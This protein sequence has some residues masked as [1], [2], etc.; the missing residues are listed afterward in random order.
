MGWR[1]LVVEDDQGLQEVTAERLRL[2][3]HTATLASNG[4]EA[5]DLC[6]NQ[7]QPFDLILMDMDMPVMGGG[8]AIACIRAHPSCKNTPILV[9]TG[10]DAGAGMKAGG[11]HFLMKPYKMAQF[12]KAIEYTF[13]MRPKLLYEARDTPSA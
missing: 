11:D 6:C 1:V 5:V 9:I 4:A 2:L 12:T 13:A 8:E 7:G 10:G 3:G